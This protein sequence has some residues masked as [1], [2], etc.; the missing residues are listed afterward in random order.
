MIDGTF[1]GYQEAATKTAVYPG[2]GEFL[3][4]L[5]ATLGLVGEAG[6]TAE[7][8]KKTWR[9]DMPN[10]GSF[11]DRPITPERRE[12]IIKELGDVFWYAA[13]VCTE[14][15]IPMS[16]VAKLNI[17]KLAARRAANLIHGEGSDR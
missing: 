17:E 5:Y 3:G 8:V 7:Q 16:E 2:Q 6:E 10:E 11:Y 4:L 14:L 15:G 13:Q 12:K 1:T 9:D